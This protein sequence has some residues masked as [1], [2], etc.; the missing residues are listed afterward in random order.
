M[1]ERYRQKYYQAVGMLA[2]VVLMITYVII[3]TMLNRRPGVETKTQHYAVLASFTKFCEQDGYSVVYL[4]P[5]ADLLTYR[6]M[7][8]S[9]RQQTYP[10]A[11]RK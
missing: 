8:G 7:A 9:L 2:A 1:A 10:L 11:T 6:C 5:S 3:N 4:Q